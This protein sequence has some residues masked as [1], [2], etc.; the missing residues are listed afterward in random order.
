MPE[1]G[2]GRVQHYFSHLNVA[3]LELYD[4]LKIGD[5]I[6]I[7]G[8]TTDLYETIDS[9]EIEH[10]RVTEGH[11]GDSVAIKVPEKVREHDEVFLVGET[12]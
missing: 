10:M 3:S 7:L 12:G 2:I 5:K 9:M 1:R 4:D 6:H 11:P 8:H